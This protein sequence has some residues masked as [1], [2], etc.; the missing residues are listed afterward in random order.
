[1]AILDLMRTIKEMNPELF[2][3]ITVISFSIFIAI[4]MVLLCEW[5]RERDLKKR[6]KHES[7]LDLLGEEVYFR[8]FGRIWVYGVVSKV[9]FDL[10]G[11]ALLWID[12]PELEE[13]YEVNFEEYGN[14]L[15]L[16]ELEVE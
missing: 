5:I 14:K 16:Q 15:F 9:V 6:K 13:Y 11:E 10:D 7:A 1:M 12:S 2:F 8:D 3:W 4:F